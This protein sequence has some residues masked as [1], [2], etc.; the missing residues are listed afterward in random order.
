[1]NDWPLIAVRFGTY[2]TLAALF[3]LSAFGLYGLRKGER[4]HGLALRYWLAGSAAAALLLSASW[5]EVMASSMAD[6]APW[7][8]D[9]AALDAILASGAI[10]TSWKVRMI[11]L[12]IAGLA[13]FRVAWLWVV[14]LCGAI[15]LATLAW[16]G[17]GAVDEGLSGWIHLVADV[18]HLIASGAWVGALVGL[19]LLVARS[20]RD[21]DREHLGLTHRAL[22][23][24]GG[25]A[26]S[27][28]HG[29]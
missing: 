26:F 9:R 21:V 14:T 10:A 25:I 16:T 15:A 18:L 20:A 5:L 27:A 7:P 8:I 3:G 11:A 1:M 23:G 13:S 19:V 6:V 4:S 17:H 24:F 28:E 2:V 12:I 22:H 29:L